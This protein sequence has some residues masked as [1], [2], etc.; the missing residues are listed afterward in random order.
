MLRYAIAKA[1]LRH[2]AEQGQTLVEYGLILGLISL[3][4]L[5]GIAALSGGALDLYGVV[6][7]AAT[8]MAN[9]VAGGSC[10]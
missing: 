4:G 5:V 7:T 6:Q 1:H 3:V 9:I 8:C 10:V 2:R